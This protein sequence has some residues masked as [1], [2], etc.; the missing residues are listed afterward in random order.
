ML[1]GAGLAR[2]PRP[3]LAADEVR[4]LVDAL[5]GASSYKVRLEA[6]GLLARSKDSRVLPALAHAA[7]SD[8]NPLVRGVVLRLLA[9]NPGGDANSDRAR[10]AIKRALNDPQAEVRA[11]AA[12]SLAELAAFSDEPA[13]PPVAHVQPR[14]SLLIAVRAMGDKTGR[15]RPE[16]RERMK[17]AVIGNLRR[18]P[19][20]AVAEGP[21]PEVAYIVDGSIARLEHGP[22]SHDLMESTCAVELVVSRPPHGIVLVA[23]GEASVQK[24]RSQFRPVLREPMDDEALEYAVKSA[25]ENLARFL[26]NN[27]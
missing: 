2:A 3:A 6:A 15:A 9:K 8:P 14:G 26:A 4:R 20:V 19:R 27:R 18:E 21:T 7:V 11:Q 13:P 1:V 5:A 16:L 17:S 12:R 10:A 24:P 25:H 22:R 23:S